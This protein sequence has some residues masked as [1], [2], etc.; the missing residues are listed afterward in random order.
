ME[1]KYIFLNIYD[2][3]SFVCI[4]EDCLV[5]SYSTR[6]GLI[7]CASYTLGGATMKLLVNKS[8]ACAFI[9]QF[10]VVLF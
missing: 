10:L 7:I 3:L 9:G 4:P 2:Y 8:I 5:D 1:N 6:L